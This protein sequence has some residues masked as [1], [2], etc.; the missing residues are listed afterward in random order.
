M[1][2]ATQREDAQ[3]TII[4]PFELVEVAKQMKNMQNNKACGPDGVPTESLRL[5][6]KIDPMLICDQMNDALEKGIPPV[7]WT[8][9]LTPL[10]KGK[11]NVT[12][13]DNYRGIKL[14]CHGMKLFE[15]LVED[16]LRHV[17]EISGTQYEF[18]QGKSTTEPIFALRMMQGKHLEKRQDLHNDLCRSRKSV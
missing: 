3:H 5:V 17:I 18:Q 1:T 10:Y 16:R 14:M 15:R 4:E 11:G 7:W 2:E 13:C 9:I 12:E 8:S 6:D